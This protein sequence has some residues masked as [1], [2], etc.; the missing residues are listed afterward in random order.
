M[1]VKGE[2]KGEVEGRQ[3]RCIIQLRIEVIFHVGGF[4]G[5]GDFDVYEDDVDAVLVYVA[6][7]FAH[8]VC[9]HPFVSSDIPSNEKRG[10][11][12]GSRGERTW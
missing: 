6:G 7:V 11:V 4:L 12:K 10:E 5:I 9:I 2:R 3:G 1:R 8:A